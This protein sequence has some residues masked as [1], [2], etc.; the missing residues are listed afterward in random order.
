MNVY[1]NSA[2]TS[3]NV[4]CCSALTTLQ[5][6]SNK[7]TSLNLTG[8]SSLTYLGCHYNQITTFYYLPT[9]LVTLY[10]NDNKLSGG[11][12]D[13]SGRSALKTLDIKN[14][15]N[16]SGLKCNNCSLT[17]LNVSGCIGLTTLDCNTNQLTSLDVSSLSNLTE[18]KLYIC[19]NRPC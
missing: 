18:L 3:L 19:L 5:C 7:L 9:S 10:C 1:S 6:Y 17:S 8:C 12:F 14:N 4:Q 2:L 16:F 11:T 13:V 15:P